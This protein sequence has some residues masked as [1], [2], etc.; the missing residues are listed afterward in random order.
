VSVPPTDSVQPG[1][2]LA[3]AQGPLLLVV[4][5]LIGAITLLAGP[6]RRRPTR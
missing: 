1:E 3:P 5:S 6:G 4:L 2:P